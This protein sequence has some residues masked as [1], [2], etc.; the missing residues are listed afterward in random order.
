MTLY[1]IND[2]QP[3]QF[4]PCEVTVTRKGLTVGVREA[5]GIAI[6]PPI[7]GLKDGPLAEAIIMSR[8][9]TEIGTFLDDDPSRGLSVYVC[10]YPTGS[11]DVAPTQLRTSDLQIEIRGLLSDN[12]SSD[13]REH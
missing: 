4:P 10:R 7:P 9:E 5:L 3:D 12:P 6:D 2:D 8:R 13:I 11:I 1:L